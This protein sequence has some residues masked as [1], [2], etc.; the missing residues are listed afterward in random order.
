MERTII[1]LLLAR[2]IC[3]YD[4]MYESLYSSRPECDWP[5][6]TSTIK[7]AVSNLRKKLKPRNITIENQYGLGWYLTKANREALIALMQERP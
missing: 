4:S 2:A 3:S 6:D 5:D 1:G 7:V